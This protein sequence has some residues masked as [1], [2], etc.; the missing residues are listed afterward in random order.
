MTSIVTMPSFYGPRGREIYVA[1]RL[2][3]Q[4][5]K[6][7]QTQSYPDR[8][9]IRKAKKRDLHTSYIMATDPVN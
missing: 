2:W 4:S 5:T 1:V 7:Q 6:T 9:V 3:A 8:G